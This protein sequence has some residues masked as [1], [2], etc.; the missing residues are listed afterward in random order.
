M[1][2]NDAYEECMKYRNGLVECGRRVVAENPDRLNYDEMQSLLSS[3]FEELNQIDMKMG[4][5][6]H[7][8]GAK[9]PKS[10]SEKRKEE[11][12]INFIDWYDV[13]QTPSN[14][15]YEYVLSHYPVNKY[16][17][18]LC[19]GDGE[20][21]HLG[22]KLAKNGY[23]AVSVDPK[24]RREFAIKKGSSSNKGSLHVVRGKFIRTSKAMID[25][26]DLIVGSK[27]TEFTE[28][29]ISLGKPTV[30][31]ISDN[32]EIYNMRFKG[33]SI[34]SSSELEEELKKC[35]GVRLEK[36]KTT[37][38]RFSNIYVFDERENELEY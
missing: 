14:D 21:V 19:V 12:Y 32:A 2:I 33:R 31:T 8:T 34:K 4:Y 35:K 38:E 5:P 7:E 11:L 28:E 15:I 37:L 20:N 9:S 36:G 3:I 17:R 16:P 18:V 29:L 22:R 6:Y 26:A 23:N 25:W 1:E 27:V 30:F 24:A 10:I 13:I